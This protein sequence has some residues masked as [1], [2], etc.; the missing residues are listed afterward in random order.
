MTPFEMARLHLLSGIKPGH[1]MKSN[2]RTFLIQIQADFH[3]KNGFLIGRIID[4]DTE[5]LNVIIRR[6]SS[7]RQGKQAR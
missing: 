3:T 5:I 6:L 2:T 4:L 1:E 7:T